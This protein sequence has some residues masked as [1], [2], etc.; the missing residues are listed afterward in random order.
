[1]SSHRTQVLR[2]HE[3]EYIYEEFPPEVYRELD[4]IDP[5]RGSPQMQPMDEINV[6]D[7]GFKIEDLAGVDTEIDDVG[8]VTFSEPRPTH[9][10]KV[11]VVLVERLMLLTFITF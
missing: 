4:R 8:I 11:S 6:S 3:T 10:N 9:L 1:M 2:R 7:H 5:P